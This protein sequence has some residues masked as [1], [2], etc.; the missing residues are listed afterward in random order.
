MRLSDIRPEHWHMIRLAYGCPMDERYASW[1]L[2]ITVSVLLPGP[3]AVITG[4][5]P[6]WLSHAMGIGEGVGDADGPIEFRTRADGL[7]WCDLHGVPA[8]VSL[9]DSDK[10]AGERARCRNFVPIIA[11]EA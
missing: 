6:V 11:T 1:S 7:A 8:Q 5:R 9:S 4:G 2:Y 3:Q 10:V